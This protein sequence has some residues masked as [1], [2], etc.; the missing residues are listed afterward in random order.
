M[1]QRSRIASGQWV[2][3][4]ATICTAGILALLLLLGLRGAG[5][6]QAASSA[7]QLASELSVRPQLLRAELTLIQRDL[8]TATYAGESLRGVGDMRDG[9]NQGYRLL[10]ERLRGANLAQDGD[11]ANPL[12]AAVQSWQ[13]SDRMIE[14]LAHSRSAELYSDTASG[15]EL[16][17][18]GKAMKRTV[19]GLLATQAQN[20]QA[21]RDNL[22]QLSG[23]LRKHVDS[24]A[25]KQR[26]LLL[27]GA[28]LATLLL[29]LVLYFAARSRFSA[30]A[31]ATAE[32]QVANILGTV[33]EGLFLV[34]RD[35]TI[36]VSHSKSL[37]ELLRVS[38]PGGQRFDDVLRPLVD[39]KTLTGAVKFIGLLWRDKVHEELIES[40]N[41]LNQIEVS[42]SN[43]YGASERRYLA[44]T[45]RRVRGED[46]VGDYVLGAVSD[47][48]DRVLLAQE[49]ETVKAENDAQS[50]LLLQ[51][52]SVNRGQLHLFLSN[53]DVAF[54][55]SNALLTKA[56]TDQ[57]ELK[58][59]LNGV[60]RELHAIKGEAAALGLA[61]FVQR[62][63][64]AED[65]LTELRRKPT[66]SGTDFVPVVVRLDDL[67]THITQIQAMQERVSTLQ[68]A[69]LP[70][71]S[72]APPI[73]RIRDTV[74]LRA[75]VDGANIPTAH[76]VQESTDDGALSDALLALAQ[77]VGRAQG[78]SVRLQ[79]RGLEHV[80]A[81]YLA[82]IR[83]VCLQ[84]IRNA[85][86]HG[87]ETPEE[88]R[89]LG[90]N[91]EG[92]VIVSFS[93]DSAEDYMLT[94]E[95]DGRG[96]NY[97]RIMNRALQQGLVRPQQAASI[98]QSALHRMIFHPGFSTAAEVSEHAGRGVGLDVV[99]DLV[100]EQ[101]GKIG[102]ASKDGQFTRFKVLLPKKEPGAAHSAA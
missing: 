72:D 23:T 88:R 40:V 82:V 85:I 55:K 84:M 46:G 57:G 61:T 54:R 5:E 87:I 35:L 17:P 10:Q 73:D 89:G 97:E 67:L 75:A 63:H 24:S 79:I 25:R 51:V 52:M 74:S 34:D 99:S 77:E 98:D 59:K 21:M 8:E 39:E 90:K 48:T 95:D 7:L 91:E 38:A 43:A 70:R 9:T 44:F 3:I 6:L 93:A 58:E 37:C 64:A 29:G 49:L 83:T 81:R 32:E 78:R 2:Q 22:L 30:A 100:R 31:A 50:T 56:G 11:V 33:R 28:A 13:G 94:F 71:A 27:A 26:A 76:P 36:G 19:D 42:F 41:P 16:T 68:P 69:A 102:V 86:T 4:T 1:A 20:M 12:A 15:S 53:A 96:L 66:L 101:S 18:A 92:T 14:S 62:I 45:F 65:V 60:F 80:P 47:V